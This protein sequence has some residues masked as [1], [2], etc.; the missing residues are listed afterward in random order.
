RNRET[1]LRSLSRQLRLVRTGRGR[2]QPRRHRAVCALG[3]LHR[4]RLPTRRGRG[5]DLG[6]PADAAAA[7]GGVGV[8]ELCIVLVH[9]LSLSAESWMMRIA[10]VLV[11]AGLAPGVAAQGPA[12]AGPAL[13]FDRVTVV[14]VETGRLVPDQ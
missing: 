2:R 7:A 11:L 14:D 1:A 10:T 12:A 5:R 4:R 13:V 8:R 3:L 6:A 9:G